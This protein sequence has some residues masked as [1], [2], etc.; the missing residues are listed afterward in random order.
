MNNLY[1]DVQRS[2]YSLQGETTSK[3]QTVE[4]KLDLIPLRYSSRS[5]LVSYSLG[6]EVARVRTDLRSTNVTLFCTIN[7]L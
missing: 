3:Y 2:T 1:A 7:R 5:T 6:Y 4:F